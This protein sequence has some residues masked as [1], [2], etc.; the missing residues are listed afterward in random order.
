MLTLNFRRHSSAAAF[1][2]AALLCAAP[3]ADVRADR[4][5][6]DFNG[7]G[8]DQ[9]GANNTETVGPTFDTLSS[10]Q[11]GQ[12]PINGIFIYATPIN[13]TGLTGF[14]VTFSLTVA[15]NFNGFV[16]FN[17]RDANGKTA[18]DFISTTSSTNGFITQSFPYSG[19]NVGAGFD[20][21]QITRIQFSVSD[22]SNLPGGPATL[23][24]D[25]MVATGAAAVPEP[26]TCA[27]LAGLGAPLLLALRRRIRLG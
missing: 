3:F 21:S 18:V 17:L 23:Q 10:Q 8:Y 13:L 9:I 12:S 1:V 19:F 26:S 5:I 25:R 2:L 14:N 16:G 20:L 27:L 11:I 15:A 4:V 24:T 6:S 7:T 22:F